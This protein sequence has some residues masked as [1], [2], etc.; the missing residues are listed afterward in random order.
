[1][2]KIDRNAGIRDGKGAIALSEKAKLQYFSRAS[3][4]RISFN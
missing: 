4:G 3:D 1:M 2:E